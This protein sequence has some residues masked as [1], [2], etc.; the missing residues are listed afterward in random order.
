MGAIWRRL[1][2][3][4]QDLSTAIWV[5]RAPLLIGVLA[6][7]IL[8]TPEQVLELYLILARELLVGVE[9]IRLEAVLQ[10]VLAVG[11]LIGLSF[12]IAYIARELTRK[13]ESTREARTERSAPGVFVRVMPSVLGILPLAGCALGLHRAYAGTTTRTLRWV[14]DLFVPGR[15]PQWDATPDGTTTAPVDP[16]V[17]EAVRQAMPDAILSALENVKS[18]GDPIYLA[19]ALCVVC[20]LGL[21]IVLPSNGERMAPRG[22]SLGTRVFRPA[23]RY[24]FYAA[25]LIL[26]V[27]FAAQ[28]LNAGQDFGFDFTSIPRMLGTLALINLSLIFLV[29]FSTMLVRLYDRHNIPLL[30][31]IV[32]LAFVFS[33]QSW[34]DNHTVRLIAEENPAK[35]NTRTLNVGQ[36]DSPRVGNAFNNWFDDRPAGYKQKFAGRPYPIYV[37]AA[38]GGGMYAANL[39]GLFLARLYDRCPA[40]RHHL[41]AVSGVSGGSVGAG[42]FA[43]LLQDSTAKE[44]MQDVCDLGTLRERENDTPANS[45]RV[46]KGPLETDIEKLL[47]TDFLAPVA[48]SFLFPDMLQRFLP[49]PIEAFDRAR[50]FEAGLEEA[51]DSLGKSGDNPL[52]RP[53]WE[54]WNRGG[55]APM[56]MLNTTVAETGRQVVLAPVDVGKKSTS[57]TPDLY[58][59]HTA[60]GLKRT[61]DVPLSTAMSLSARFPLVMPAG[62]IAGDGDQVRLVD[63]GYFENSA[64]ESALAIIRQLRESVC[65]DR[66]GADCVRKGSE[67]AGTSG[68]LE[69][70]AL[71]EREHPRFV[72]RLIILTDYDPRPDLLEDLEDLRTHSDAPLNE[73]LS[74]ARAMYNARVARGRLAVALAAREPEMK[75]VTVSLNHRLYKLPLGWQL[76][77]RTQDVIAAQIGRSDNCDYLKSSKFTNARSKLTTLERELIN[78][79]RP[80]M[81]RQIGEKGFF[82]RLRE[83]RELFE[84]RFSSPTRQILDTLKRNQCDLRDLVEKEIIS[85]IDAPAQSESAPP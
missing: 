10:V 65:P 85:A 22:R 19:V 6:F 25:C 58:S 69:T 3:G 55:D 18:L 43:A 64:V 26:T 62:R 33:W 50:A 34:N 52:R 56:L 81:T 45:R 51:W 21:L 72:F 66:K 23:A 41:F 75:T 47:Q 42:F 79:K 8:S 61:Q 78:S 39:S 31:L 16:G 49:V 1:I 63:G 83:W 67:V 54:H 84:E 40:M 35:S 20:A 29:F 13:D 17:V 53:F 7:F 11:S 38:Q 57:E 9:E 2:A 30:S 59:L 27:L 14:T 46:P 71:A 76:S 74:P 70:G 48:A 4:I 5:L 68:V 36:E 37:V 15:N 60:I 73:T 44:P 12:F 24:V 32:V 28:Y 82:E 80:S 77:T